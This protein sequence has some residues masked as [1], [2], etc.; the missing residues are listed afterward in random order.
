MNITELQQMNRNYKETKDNKPKVRLR[1]AKRR[2]SWQDI[3]DLYS[4]VIQYRF[5]STYP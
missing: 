4:N 1:G 2:E 5:G 3:A